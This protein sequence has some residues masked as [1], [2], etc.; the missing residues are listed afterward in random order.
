MYASCIRTTSP[1]MLFN[2]SARFRKALR[3]TSSTSKSMIG[4]EICVGKGVVISVKYYTRW[5]EKDRLEI[6]VV[7]ESRNSRTRTCHRIVTAWRL[8]QIGKRQ[9]L[10]LPK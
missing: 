1:H 4:D 5:I 2:P 9:A 10:Q 3:E 6:V 7:A 8:G